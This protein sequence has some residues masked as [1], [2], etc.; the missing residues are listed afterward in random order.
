MQFEIKWAAGRCMTDM[1]SVREP[2]GAH[3]PPNKPLQRTVASERL[4]HGALV[5]AEAHRRG[6]VGG[7]MVANIGHGGEPVQGLGIEVGVAGKG[8]AVQ[9]ALADVTDRPLDL[10]L[11]LC[12]V[13]ATGADPEAP[14]GGE[15]QELGILED[16]A[17]LGATILQNDG[18][19]LIEEQLTE[20]YRLHRATYVLVRRQ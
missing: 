17:S 16:A 5:A 3:A 18:L 4:Q 1:V 15:A 14:V 20:R 10:A 12:A 6:L 8:A 7:A 19:E 11:G 13:G 2:T 9:E